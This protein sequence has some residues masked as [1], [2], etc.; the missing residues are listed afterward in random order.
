LYKSIENDKYDNKLD[1]LFTAQC[2]LIMGDDV[3]MSRDKFLAVCYEQKL[4]SDEKQNAFI[5]CYNDRDL[6][7]TWTSF[8]A[9][10]DD[11]Y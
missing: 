10:W 2:D 1:D 11:E 9:K 3:G 7:K 8:T 6:T 4:F 5:G